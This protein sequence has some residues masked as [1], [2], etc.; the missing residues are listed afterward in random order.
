MT[1]SYNIDKKG[2]EMIKTFFF[3]DQI[4]AKKH[5]QK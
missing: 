1:L 4:K 3:I 5:L 2:S